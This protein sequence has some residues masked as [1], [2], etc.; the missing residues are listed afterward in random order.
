MYINLLQALK[1]TE[2]ELRKDVAKSCEK[3]QQFQ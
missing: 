1:K 3:Q 2:T